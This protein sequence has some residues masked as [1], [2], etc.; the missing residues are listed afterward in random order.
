MTDRTLPNLREYLTVAQAA[1]ILG[2]TA[3]TVRA[4]GSAGK[5]P[6]RRNP[7]NGYRLFRR[8]DLEAFL[9]LLDRGAPEAEGSRSMR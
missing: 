8:A 7:A 1:S 2:V 9:A 3:N 4:W 6:S 5:I